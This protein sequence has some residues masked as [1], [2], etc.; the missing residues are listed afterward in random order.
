MTVEV[1]YL[2]VRDG[3]EVAMY[4]TK[5]EA[6][7]HDRMLDIASALAGFIQQADTVTLAEDTL[8]ELCVYLSK[9]REELMRVLRGARPH[10]T[11]DGDSEETP[12]P[13]KGRR[14]RPPASE[15]QES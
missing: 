5:K 11:V 15:K 10:E 13:A 1:R 7:E 2:V 14:G 9:N 3:K 6:D 12:R 4:L 8:E